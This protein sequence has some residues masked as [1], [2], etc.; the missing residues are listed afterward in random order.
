MAER[1]GLGFRPGASGEGAKVVADAGIDVLLLAHDAVG[2][3]GR[4]A[5]SV[6]AWLTASTRGAGLVA[7][8]PV[9]WA[10]FHVARALASFDLLSGGRCG[11][12]PARGAIGTEQAAEHLEVVRALF[13]SWDDDALALDKASSI[14]AD[15]GK[16]RRIRHAGA[17]YTVDGPLNAPRPPQGHPVLFQPLD[18][19]D[20]QTD[21][22]LAPLQRLEA[23]GPSSPAARTFAEI[24]ISHHDDAGALAA[25]LL[26]ALEAGLCDGVVL[27]AREPAADAVWLA[28][29]L[30]P[31][32]RTHPKFAPPP[33]GALRTRLGLARPGNRYSD[34]AA[35][36]PV[37]A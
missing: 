30:I 19:A 5:L 25:Q 31:R 2:P 8:V 29:T 6:A 23:G 10:P 11:W 27:A 26:A 4:D 22:A 15:R 33:A 32:L 36:Q 9:S 18:E 34:A 37:M 13:D 3:V 12:A 1:W 14:F 17:F 7:E 24:A 20:A 28:Q 21:I 35:A 16:V